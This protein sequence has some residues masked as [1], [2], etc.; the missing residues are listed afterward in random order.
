MKFSDILVKG[1]K[2]TCESFTNP[3]DY[4]IIENVAQF[5]LRWND[6]SPTRIHESWFEWDWE[7]VGTKPQ[8]QET[9]EDRIKRLEQKVS[10]L[11][12]TIVDTRNNVVAGRP[13]R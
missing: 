11:L 13:Y 3:D 6:D 10:G 2:Y 5:S 4:I 1:G 9:L 8:V 7:P 12:D